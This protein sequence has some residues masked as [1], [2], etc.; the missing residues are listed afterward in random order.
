MIGP[1]DDDHAI[2]GLDQVAESGLTSLLGECELTPLGDP[3]QAGTKEVRVERLEEVVRRA[4]TEG[5]DRALKVRVAGDH[6]DGRGRGRGLESRHEVFS[7]CIGKPAIE[8]DRRKSV[9][10][11][12]GQCFGGTT[13]GHDP[14]VVEL[15]NVAKVVP[16]IGIV[17]D[18]KDV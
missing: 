2:R 16:R 15:Q 12:E 8:D 13:H 18:H 17:L 11:L 7:Q 14:V 1:E 4:L 5:G 9:P 10:V 6:D 3:G